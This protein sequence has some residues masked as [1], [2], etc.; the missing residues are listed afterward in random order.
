MP[1]PCWLACGF[2]FEEVSH[3]SVCLR[4]RYRAC[5]PVAATMNAVGLLDQLILLSEPVL[6][7]CFIVSLWK[8]L[9][10]RSVQR[11]YPL[12]ARIRWILPFSD[13]WREDV[14]PEHL[15][16]IRKFRTTFFPY[17]GAI[18]AMPLLKAGYYEF[19][20]VTLHSIR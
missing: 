2:H 14:A 16:G 8:T 5:W 6:W 17:F 1:L 11:L 20:F 7:L 12:G 19:L 10:P 4:C 15:E 3:E 13:R 9:P 18:L